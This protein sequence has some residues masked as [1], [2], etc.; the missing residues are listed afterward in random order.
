MLDVTYA[1]LEEVA[2]AMSR[3]EERRF[4][5]VGSDLHP[6]GPDPHRHQRPTSGSPTARSSTARSS[7]R[8]GAAAIVAVDDDAR[9]ARPPAARADRRPR[10]AGGPGRAPGPG[11]R[12]AAGTPPSAS[13]PRRSAR[14]PTLDAA[15]DVL[16]V[17]RLHDRGRPPVPGRGP[18]RR[19][20]RARLRRGRAHRDRALAA[21]RPRRALRRG[22][23]L[24]DADGPA[25]LRAPAPALTRATLL[26][27][28]EVGGIRWT[29][30][31]RDGHTKSGAVPDVG[32]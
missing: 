24:Q 2:P 32:F 25:A 9:L 29:A 19:R 5:R 6:R 10:L 16:L 26:S 11:R 4:E 23:R 31:F 15:E 14:S 1:L 18:A 13:W 20:G 28:L 27:E 22:Q 30:H 3:H 21:G 12:V 8:R 7:T 17:G